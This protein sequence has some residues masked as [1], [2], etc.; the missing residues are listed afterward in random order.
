M[1]PESA[2]FR[3]AR[4]GLFI[5]YGLYAMLGRGEW[6][7]NREHIPIADYRRLAD[8]FI[9]DRLDF[10]RLLRRAKQDWGM[11]YAVMTCKHHDGFCLYD[12]KL[13]DFTSC[14]TRCRRDLVGEFV[15]AC[16]KH[17]LRIA[18]YHTLNDWVHSPNAVDALE[19]PKEC[20]QP[21]MDFVSGQIREILTNYGKID[22]LWYD[23]WWPFDGQG[24][25]AEKLNAMAR[26]LQPGILLNGRCGIRGDFDTPEGHIT[27]SP[28]DRLWEA[29]INLNDSGGY[30]KGDNNWKSPKQVVE[31][32]RQC[33]AGQG[34]LMLNLAPK[35]DGSI[36]ETWEHCVE[37]VGAW[38]RRHGE[39]IYTRQRFACSLHGGGDGFRGEWTNHGRFSASGQAFYWHIRN[40]PGN[41]LR[42]VGVECEVTDVT[43][44][45]SGDSYAFRQE[46][47]RVTV[48]GVPE[49]MS[50]DMPVVMRFRVK[51]IPRLYN[52]AGYDIPKVSHCRYDP[53]PSDLA[54]IL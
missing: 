5:Q 16:R 41:P 8:D 10:D 49:W 9:A 48:N 11:R 30:H 14:K 47:N 25:Q 17:G 13:T 29:Y 43:E 40:W 35:G 32:L 33:A 36:P 53:L 50:T 28:G 44:L 46:G 2:W 51:G 4:Y 23:G 21:F 52:C 42:L 3:E 7:L 38:L 15:E 6:V 27:M 18:L 54:G 12:S 24:W 19:R 26:Q 1:N 45:A 37:T 20:H 22:V 34:N 39:S 31:L